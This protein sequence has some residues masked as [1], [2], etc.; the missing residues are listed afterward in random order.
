[1]R[2]F[3]LVIGY[4]GTS[5]HG[6]QAQPGQR[7]VQGVLVETLRMLL[8]G[9]AI[10]VHG[11][12]RTDAGVHARGQVASFQ[13][14]TR[15]PPRAI[16]AGLARRLPPDVRVRSIGEADAGFHARHSACGRRY[17]Y[18]LLRAD[19]PLFS[20]FAWHPRHAPDPDALE[21]ATRALE[22]EHDFSAFQ[23]AG[24]TRVPPECRVARA[25]WGRWEGGVRLDIVADRFLYHMVRNVVGT[26]LSAA[27]SP[28]PAEAMRKVLAGR[29]RRCAGV[30]APAHGLCF[31]EVFYREAGA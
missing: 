12:G 30:T 11:A 1:M 8:A 23:A 17:A 14:A 27:A 29:D 7:T 22:G 28:D 18:R 2:T 3:R 16:E 24:S 9:E 13:S 20:R 26:A 15:L 21:R 25:R 5:F 31:E 10:D 4:D 6:W 19:D